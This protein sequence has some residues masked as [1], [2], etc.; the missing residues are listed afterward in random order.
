V[1]EDLTGW[2]TRSGGADVGAEDAVTRPTARS[3]HLGWA[4]LVALLSISLQVST[5]HRYG[6]TQ[7]EPEHWFFG[8]RYLQFYLT[9]DWQALDFTGARWPAIQTWPVGPTLAAATSKLFADRLGLVDRTDGHHLAAVLLFGLLLGSLWLFLAVHADRLVAAFA[10]LALALQPRLWGDAHN[11]SQDIA[12]LTFYTLATLALLHGARTRRAGWLLASGA[13]WGLALGSKINAVSLPLVVAPALISLGRDRHR[14]PRQV[15]R[16]LAAAPLVAVA[17]FALAWPYLWQHPLERLSRFWSYL[18]FWGYTGH[19]VWQWS[20]VVNVLLTTPLPIL[21]AAVLGAGV[22]LWGRTGGVLGRPASVTLLLWL[23]VPIVRTSLPGM[24][25][26]NVIRRFMEFTPALAIFAGIGTAWL[27]ERLDQGGRGVWGPYRRIARIARIAVVATALSP[28]LAI[29]RYFPYESSYYNSLIGGLQ[30][31]QSRKLEEATDYTLTSYR[32]GIAWLNAHADPGSFILVGHGPHLVS[33]YPL[34]TDLVLREDV[35]MDELPARGRT[36]YLMYVPLDIYTYN[37]C[38]AEAFLRPAYEIRR[39]GGLILRIYRLTADAG[40][41]VVRNAF[42]PP[43]EFSASLT[44]RWVTLR[45][46]PA[47]PVGD[48]VGYIVYYGRAPRQY[49]GSACIRGPATEWEVFADVGPGTYYLSMS[50]LTRGA[51]ES[52]RTPDIRKDYHD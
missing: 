44:R 31:A 52:E 23:A 37:M 38:L 18:V 45:W 47:G 48:L 16:A 14:R 46:T 4:V 19:R 40:V 29:W 42:P 41:T 26:Y 17:L 35:W 24:L 36:V 33:Y 15:L 3:R 50:V 2:C 28:V 8:D 49:V 1:G 27:V 25:N 7:D 30:G 34:R 9:G 11:N 21:A 12:H 10:C 51:Q 20:P 32:E 22:A 5:L 13:A 39:G 6:V 43:R